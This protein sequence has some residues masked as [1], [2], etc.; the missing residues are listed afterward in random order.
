[1]QNFKLFLPYLNLLLLCVLFFSGWNKTH[2]ISDFRDYYRASQLLKEKEDIY[3]FEEIKAIQTQYTLDNLFQKEVYEKLEKMKGNIAS[4]IYPPSF[5]VLVY[6]LTFTNYETASKIFF[7]INFLSLL[8]TIYLLSQMSFLT[9]FS[10]V[11]FL[12]LCFSYRFLENHTVNNQVGLLLMFLTFLSVYIKNDNWSGALLSLAVIIKLTPA[13]FLLYFFTTKRWKSLFYFGIFF[14][15]WAIL[16]LLFEYEYGL[17]QWK[18]WL[19]M[20]L[21]NAMKTPLFR[22]WK[23]NQSLIATLAKY[24]LIGADP[25]NQQIFNLP[26][27]SLSNQFIKNLFTIL[28]IGLI[29]S[30]LWKVKTGLSEKAYI[31]SLFILSVVLSGISWVHS[32]VV[33]FIPIYFLT[34]TYLDHKSSTFGK[35]FIFLNLLIIFT[36][37]TFIGQVEN[38]FL[39]FSIFLYI[40]LGYYTLLIFWKIE[41]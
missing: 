34:E 4:Y 18:N 26:F 40:S 20:V 31:S 36:H 15:V 10:L 32:F 23:N 14:L 16:P 28:A 7:L 38:L 8:G 30:L 6:P 2:L 41:D 17:Q 25:I 1:M 13:I 3:Q 21:F 29:S 11:L 19:E 22:A 37:K 12:G 5:S 39:M 9:N 33:L 27:I 24:F 35:I